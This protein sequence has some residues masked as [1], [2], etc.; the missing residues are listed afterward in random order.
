VSHLSNGSAEILDAVT[1]RPAGWSFGDTT[2][3]AS[4]YE[5]LEGN[6]VTPADGMRA[7]AILGSR[8][9]SLGNPISRKGYYERALEACTPGTSYEISGWF[10]AAL[11][12]SLSPLTVKIDGAVLATFLRADYADAGWHALSVPFVAAGPTP[13]LRLEVPAPAVNGSSQWLFDGLEVLSQDMLKRR[14]IEAGIV[15]TVAGVTVAN[16]YPE[17]IV[18]VRSA[19]SDLK[20]IARPGAIVTFAGPEIKPRDRAE[21]HRK[22][23]IAPFVIWIVADGD[24]AEARVQDLGGSVETALEAQDASGRWLGGVT[25]IDDVWVEHSDVLQASPDMAAG[26]YVAELVVGVEYR[27]NRLV[28]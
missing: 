15:A 7:F 21:L 9:G 14:E 23:A 27:H 8:S 2:G 16:G 3:Q 25:G 10:N 1:G 13:L 5:P 17:G 24:N 6:A 4:T 20:S 11:A 26:V 28:P 12:S 18:E 22:K 19:P